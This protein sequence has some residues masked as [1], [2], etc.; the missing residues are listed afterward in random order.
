[1]LIKL[2]YTKAM[3]RKCQTIFNRNGFGKLKNYLYLNGIKY[4]K[5]YFIGRKNYFI[6]NTQ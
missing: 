5:G 6:I 1:M 4:I 3:I 2:G